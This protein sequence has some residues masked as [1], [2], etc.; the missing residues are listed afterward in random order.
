MTAEQYLK[1]ATKTIYN[2]HIRNE[3]QREL[4]SCIEDLTQANLKKGMTQPEAEE[5]AVKQMGEP[6][7]ISIDFHKIYRPKVEWK[8]ILWYAA[9]ATFFG[10]FKLGGVLT[11]FTNTE[12]YSTVIRGVGIFFIVFGLC[13]SLVE[14]YMDLPFFYSWANNWGGTGLGGIANSGIISGL[15][16]GLAARNVMELLLL[17]LLM[18]IIF[19]LQR[20]I[21]SRKREAKEQKY[22]WES[23]TAQE[24]FNY[25]GKATIG[26]E[27]KKVRVKKGEIAKKG[28][29]LIITGIK[30][31]T[32]MVEKGNV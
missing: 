3:V 19:Q 20:L 7:D 24:D 27:T 4:K 10:A 9:W 22:L 23:C 8:E 14:K 5:T 1:K 18:I 21:I 13:W 12:Y 16:T 2:A 15:G 6:D 32:L 11:V 29:S 30:G 25:Q 31:F 28:D 26:N 17:G